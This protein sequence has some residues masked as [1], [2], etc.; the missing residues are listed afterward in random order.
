MIAP[1]AVLPVAL[2]ITPPSTAPPPVPITAPFCDLVA[3]LQPD[4]TNPAIATIN[5][6][7]L[8]VF[9]NVLFAE[10]FPITV[11]FTGSI[12]LTALDF[13]KALRDVGKV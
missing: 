11:P 1:R 7:C 6:K 10:V 2:P 8:I 9:M 12:P 4:A 13:L 3:V 5:P